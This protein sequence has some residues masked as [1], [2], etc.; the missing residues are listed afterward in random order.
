[1]NNIETRAI[2]FAPGSVRERKQC[3]EGNKLAKRL[4]RLAGNTPGNSGDCARPQP[5]AGRSPRTPGSR[6]QARMRRA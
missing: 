6:K 2:R 5:A 1:M 4:R 3:Y